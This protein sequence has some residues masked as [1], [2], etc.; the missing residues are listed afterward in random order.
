MRIM[1]LDLGERRV[2]VA[3]SDT[4]GM[5]AQPHSTLEITGDRMLSQAI[6]RLAAE[7]GVTRIV[8]GYPL[9]SDGT[10]G[11][12]AQRVDRIARVLANE[13]HLPVEKID[14][15][16]TSL[17]AQRA[18]TKAPAKVRRDKGSLDRMA[19]AIILQTYL[20]SRRST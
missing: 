16:F 11:L 12:R 5:T 13:T 20:D 7:H 10:V 15:R 9:N 17:Q 3:L 8:V 6:K 14:E 19:A 4:L 18:L 1:G 2:G